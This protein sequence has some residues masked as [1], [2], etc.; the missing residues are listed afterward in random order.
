MRD[1]TLAAPSADPA[2]VQ[3]ESLERGSSLWR[4]AWLRLQ[5]NRVALFGF[6]TF[7]LI[8]ILCLAGPFFTGYSYESTEISLRASAPLER[9]VLETEFRK[10]GGPKES[11]LALSSLE[12]EFL[13]KS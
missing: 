10:V 7:M 1:G 4:D 11:Y 13:E 3:A 9:I 2:P 8:A 12:D 6:W 5:K